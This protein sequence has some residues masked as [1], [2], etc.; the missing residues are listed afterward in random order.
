MLRNIS[1]PSNSIGDSFGRKSRVFRNFPDFALKQVAVAI[2][3]FSE[4]IEEW[5]S[6]RSEKVA[7]LQCGEFRHFGPQQRFFLSLSP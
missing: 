6:R 2:P 7:M 3:L 4:E 5:L 1:Y